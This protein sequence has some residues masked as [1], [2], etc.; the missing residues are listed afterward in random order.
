MRGKTVLS[1]AR[2]GQKTE[3]QGRWP[4]L[5]GALAASLVLHGLVLISRPPAPAGMRSASLQARL[6]ARPATPPAEMRGAEAARKSGRL[7]AKKTGPSTPAASAQPALPVRSTALPA[8]TTPQALL[9]ARASEG[10]DSDGLIEF[11]LNFAAQAAQYGAVL[12][13]FRGRLEI[14][15][16]IDR[17]G[18]VAPPVI[19]RG[20][21]DAAFDA[22]ALEMFGQIARRVAVPASL[23]GQAF[24]LVLPLEVG[25]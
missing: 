12:K 4:G 2:C 23:R 5:L 8:A 21:G 13:R 20:S 11:R 17:F 18:F 1:N 7:L 22:Y 25:V 14:G 9:L 10:L 3:N 16:R 19:V 6:A 15:L 24:S